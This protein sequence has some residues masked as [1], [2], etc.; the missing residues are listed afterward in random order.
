MCTIKL[1]HKDKV[2]TSRFFVKPRNSNALL[3]MLDIEVLGILKIMCEVISRQQAGRKS[4]S[5]I[6]QPTSVP[7]CKTHTAQDYRLDSM[8]TNQSNINMLDYVRPCA[9]KESD[10]EASRSITHK[11]H[12]KFSDDFTGIGCF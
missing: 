10:N 2:V 5:Q 8:G 9:N 4:D 11:N 1:R 12:S 7:N 6:R 3:G